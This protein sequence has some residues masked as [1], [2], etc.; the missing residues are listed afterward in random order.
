[1]AD[2]ASALVPEILKI[3]KGMWKLDVYLHRQ[4]DD[5]TT[6]FETAKWVRFYRLQTLRN[7]PP[8]PKSVSYDRAARTASWNWLVLNAESAIGTLRDFGTV[9]L[10]R[11]VG[12][13][14]NLNLS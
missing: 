14:R 10:G 13:L 11:E 7:R 3:P 12:T 2:A 1:M 4:A 6:C 5:L 8:R 9:S